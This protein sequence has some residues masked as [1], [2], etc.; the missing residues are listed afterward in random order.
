MIKRKERFTSFE[1]MMLVLFIIVLIAIIMPIYKSYNGGLVKADAK[2]DMLNIEQATNMAL[3]DIENNSDFK[4][5]G[6]PDGQY[7]TG[8]EDMVDY[9]IIDGNTIPCL[10]NKYMTKVSQYMDKYMD[11]SG[12]ATVNLLIVK[13]KLVEI[14]YYDKGYLTI[15]MC[16]NG[17]DDFLNSTETGNVLITGFNHS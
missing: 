8:E 10:E 1:I 6:S 4:N 11:I 9:I 16:N 15:L 13:D 17:R 3:F 12:T 2:I 5:S 7:L 14:R